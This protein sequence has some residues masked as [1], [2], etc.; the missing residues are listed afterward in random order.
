MLPLPFRPVLR[1]AG[2]L[3][4]LSVLAAGCS[5]PSA[6]PE[7]APTE[8]TAVTVTDLM[9]R[10]VRVAV[11]VQRMILG[12]S[13]QT[14]VTAML[15]TD[16]PFKRVVGWPDD[17][18]TTDFDAYA[19]YRAKFPQVAAIPVL[20]GINAGQFSAEQAIALNP[21]LLVLNSDAYGKATDTGLIAQLEKAGIPTV[22]IDYR[23][24][25]LENTVPTT[26][27][28]GKLLGKEARAQEVVDFYLQQINQIYARLAKVKGPNPS[29]FLFRTAGLSDCCP[30]FGRASFG[31]MVERAKGTHIGSDLVPGFNGV[32]NPEKVLAAN[33]QMIIAT[34]SN[35]AYNGGGMGFVTLGYQTEPARATQQLRAV[36]GAQPGWKGLTATQQGDLYAVWH[37]FYNSPYNFVAFQQIAKW[38]HPAEFADLDPAATFG[39]FH[40]RFLPIDLTGSFWVGARS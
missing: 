32:L 16:D 29:V 33:P 1:V 5:Q 15:D 8:R 38:L 26:I 23:E 39:E 19:K 9:G 12:E 11:P 25:P 3:A 40:Q 27:L 14:Y 28:M 6:S 18:R 31:L 36:V 22:V 21:D 35:W 2:L 7:P 20:G 24:Y 34:G 37:Q 4:A 30:T 10:Q 13:R 17:L